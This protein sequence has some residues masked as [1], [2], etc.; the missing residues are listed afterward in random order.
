MSPHSTR[1]TGFTL[2][3]LLV[4][5]AII[6]ILIGLLL[7][8]VQKVREAAARS[9]SQNNLHQMVIAV[10]NF[11]GVQKSLPD[12]YGDSYYDYG[13]GSG[14]YY[15]N[16]NGYCGN[17][18]YGILP[19]ME[20][21][22]NF[23]SGKFNYTNTAVYTNGNYAYGQSGTA[24]VSWK[25]P[26]GVVKSYVAPGDP[27]VGDDP[28]NNSPVSYLPNGSV[29]TSSKNLSKIRNGTSNVV[30]F[31]EGYASCKTAVTYYWD[32]STTYDYQRQQAW[33]YG[34][35]YQKGTPYSNNPYYTMTLYLG[36][37]T[38]DYSQPNYW[39]NPPIG[40]F[41][42]KPAKNKCRY[43]IAQSLSGGALMLGM[44]DGSVR[45]MRMSVSQNAWYGAV[46]DYNYGGGSIDN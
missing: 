21:Q 23:N 26:G 37:Y 8:A 4:V 16:G 40:P 44:G 17:V 12:T 42:D 7:P 10:H 24:Y 9:Q 30:M 29:L 41:Q 35:Y 18:F 25:A 32:P 38:Y 6:A 46:Y 28:N 36:T 20:Q 27:T 39:Q 11:E 22:A 5:I 13:G 1:R 31:T 14:Y 19:Y 45:G 3:E 43:D 33:N 34:D 15:S 2:I